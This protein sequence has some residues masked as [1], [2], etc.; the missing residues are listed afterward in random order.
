MFETEVQ[1]GIAVLEEKNL[2]WRAAALNPD[3]DMARAD[4]CVLGF[5]MGDYWTA[6][7]TWG[8]DSA[9]ML[10]HGFRIS[11]YT[12]DYFSEYSELADAWR[13][14]AELTPAG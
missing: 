13:R 12:E 6:R 4:R 8:V 1:A 7:D 9:W 11:D 10:D 5:T 3:L 2:D 14:A